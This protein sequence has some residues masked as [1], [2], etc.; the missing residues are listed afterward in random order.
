MFE[1]TRL[2]MFFVKIFS[3]VS[4]IRYWTK[5]RNVLVFLYICKTRI[6]YKKVGN[7]HSDYHYFIK[8]AVFLKK[9]VSNIDSLYY[10]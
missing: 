6:S 5:F 3:Y 2:K 7:K 4:Y 8:Y 9:K 10:F 1:L